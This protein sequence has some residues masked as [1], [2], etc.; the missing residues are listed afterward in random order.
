MSKRWMLGWAIVGLLSGAPAFAQESAKSGSAPQVADVSIVVGGQ[1]L[2]N[3]TPPIT[4][5]GRVLIPLRKVFNALGASVKYENKMIDSQRGQQTVQLSPGSNAAKING[6]DVL[7][8]VPPLLVGTV[9]YVPLRFVAQALG[10]NVA[11]DA[12]AKTV[13]VTPGEGGA[14]AGAP[15]GMPAGPGLSAQ[16]QEALKAM[17]KRLTVGHQGAILKVWDEAGKEVVYYRGLD[18]RAT[19]PYDDEDQLKLLEALGVGDTQ[20]VSALAQEVMDGFTQLPRRE[21][22]A[23]LGLIHSIEDDSPLE[24]NDEV[25]AALGRFLVQ[26]MRSDKDVMVRRQACLALAVGDSDVLNHEILNAILEFY[27]GSQN[28]WETFPVQ[29][30]FEFQASRIRNMP[31]LPEVRERVAS[32]NSLYTPAALR[33][34]DGEDD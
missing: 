6:Q 34:L 17:L 9:T 18:D 29:Q 2:D 33:Y 7:L 1:K 23:F 22:V 20:A 15:A 19:A 32:V 26:A 10:S 14:S 25:D 21:A 5:N 12:A 27:A 11:Y 3:E 4:V 31:T 28:L 24:P 13:T 30:F 16:R 8:D